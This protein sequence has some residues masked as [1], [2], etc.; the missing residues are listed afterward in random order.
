MAPKAITHEHI[1]QSTLDLLLQ[2]GIPY[3]YEADWPLPESGRR[4]QIRDEKHNAPKREVD[5]IR[6]ALAAGRRV[7]PPIVTRD[8]YYVD[9]NTRGGAYEKAGVKRAHAIVLEV[10][11][12]KASPDV[13]RKLKGLGAALNI[14]HGNR[15]TPDEVRDAILVLAE[16]PTL[17]QY[18]GRIAELLGEPKAAVTRVLRRE[19]GRQFLKDQGHTPNGAMTSG[20]L[21]VFA[22][23]FKDWHAEPAKKITD[24]AVAAD[25]NAEELK[26]LARKV[27]ATSSDSEAVSVLTTAE[28]ELGDRVRRVQFHGRGKPTIA[29][30]MRRALGII[31]NLTT[32]LD[33]AVDDDPSS[34]C[35]YLAELDKALERLRAL[36]DLQN[37]RGVQ[38]GLDCESNGD[39]GGGGA[40]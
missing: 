32:D 33:R 1:D 12:E 13:Q 37:E 36:R 21:N 26:D 15:L 25:L 9:G 31:A 30:K 5:R 27:E 28:G 22:S 20:V 10:D 35:S 2:Y 17:A 6:A 23:R 38:L 18:P 7:P 39:G 19:R 11:F 24:I 16:D 4:K 34:A 3:R 14:V 29:G 8:G 40:S